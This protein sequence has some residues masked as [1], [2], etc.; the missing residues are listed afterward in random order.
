M[1]LHDDTLAACH[2]AADALQRYFDAAVILT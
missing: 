1:K 2:T